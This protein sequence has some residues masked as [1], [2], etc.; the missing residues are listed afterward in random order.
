MKTRH[1]EKSAWSMRNNTKHPTLRQKR[2]S[3]VRGKKAK[4][5]CRRITRIAKNDDNR[6]EYQESVDGRL[7]DIVHYAMRRLLKSDRAMY[8]RGIGKDSKCALCPFRALTRTCGLQDR[9][10]QYHT[11]EYNWGASGQKQIRERCALY[12]NDN[13]SPNEDA[14]FA[15]SPNYIRRPADIIRAAMLR[16]APGVES[17]FPSS[18]LIGRDIRL[19]QYTDG[20]AFR[21]LNYVRGAS[22]RYRKR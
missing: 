14:V 6:S 18:N 11:E 12:A 7:A 10:E 1:R 4:S 8:S 5:R 20:H 13:M 19:V 21:T 15:P 22:G 9:M 16:G 2:E 3:H 17:C